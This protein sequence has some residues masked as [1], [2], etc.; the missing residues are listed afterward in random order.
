MARHK[1]FLKNIKV[2]IVQKAH[3]CQHN[4]SHRL[5]KGMKRLKLSHSGQRSPEHFCKSCAIEGLNQDLKKIE[6]ILD[7]LES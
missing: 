4:S 7:E 2:D 5:E 6:K 1:S 3:N